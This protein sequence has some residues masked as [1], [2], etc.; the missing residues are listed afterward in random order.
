[1]AIVDTHCHASPYWYEPVEV[2]L[3]QMQRSG[4]EKAALIQIIGWYDNAYPLECKRRFPGKF[5]V[6]AVV[7]TDQP[8]AP[9][10][11]ESWAAQ[12]VE[13]VRLRPDT[14]SP[15]ADPLAIWRKA[16]ELGA[17]VSC[18]GAIGQYAAPEFEALIRELPHLNIIIEHLG[19]VGGLFGDGDAAPPHERYRQVLALAQYPNVYMKVPGLGEISRRAMPVRAPFPFETPPSFIEMAVDAFGANRLMWGSD[20]PPSAAREGYANTLRLPMERLA[21]LSPEDR[22]WIFGQTAESLWRFE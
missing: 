5:S 13:G 6:V 7:D 2:L 17:P 1:M 20:F 21:Y 10:T 15:G 22:A 11:L 14:R 8:D 12:G 16:A 9:Q 18:V 3:E 4:V 19:G